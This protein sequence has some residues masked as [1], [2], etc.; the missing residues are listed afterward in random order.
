[1]YFNFEDIIDKE[2]IRRR[3]KSAWDIQNPL[4]KLKSGK[5][6]LHASDGIRP[7]DW[8]CPF[9]ALS[10]KQRNILIK[11]E[12]IR[13]YDRLLLSDKK[14]LTNEACLSTFQT[15]WYKM[16]SIDKQKL[17]KHILNDS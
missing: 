5:K 9:D 11:G 8:L 7:I 17:L 16:S 2:Q 12:L 10:E 14:K 1:M 15:K 4:E 3:A 6:Y 13:T